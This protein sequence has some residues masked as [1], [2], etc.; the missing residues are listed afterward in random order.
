[1]IP[2]P[3]SQI[4]AAADRLYRLLP[5]HIRSTDAANGWALRALVTVLASGS[6]EIDRE[7]ETLYAAIF[8]ESAPEAALDA[9]AALVGAEPLRPLPPGGGHNA[10]AYIANTLRYRR[11]KGTARILEALAADVGGY[12]AAVVEYFMRLARTQNL[13]DVRP[14]KT[15]RMGVICCW[16]EYGEGSFIEPTK[17][18]GKE[19]LER[20]RAVFGQ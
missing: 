10:R 18:M 20:V 7:I 17:R 11:G 1:M 13:I 15:L 19:L 2:L 9:I 14:E 5:E 3:A 4:E 8:V 6:A 16:N 12:G